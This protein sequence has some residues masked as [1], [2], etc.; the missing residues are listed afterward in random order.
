MQL[1]ALSE[2]LTDEV[3]KSTQLSSKIL[4]NSIARSFLALLSCFSPF[5]HRPPLSIFICRCSIANP[6]AEGGER[7]AQVGE[8]RPHPRRGQAH[9]RRIRPKDGA[10]GGGSLGGLAH[11]LAGLQQLLGGERRR[12]PQRHPQ[13]HQETTDG[14]QQQQQCLLK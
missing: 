8:P 5:L 11:L 9:G 7:A 14:Q 13:D 2:N 10:L 6:E 4:E 3:I 1:L 12:Y